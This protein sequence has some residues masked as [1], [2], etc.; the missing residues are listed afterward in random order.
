[1]SQ[2]QKLTSE[3]LNSGTN[4]IKTEIH[5]LAAS[6]VMSKEFDKLDEDE[7]KYMQLIS[8]YVTSSFFVEESK[9]IQVSFVQVIQRIASATQV[10]LRDFI[11][12]KLYIIS[13]ATSLISNTTMLPASLTYVYIIAC[14]GLVS[15]I[16]SA[17]RKFDDDGKHDYEQLLLGIDA[18][19]DELVH[20]INLVFWWEGQI[21]SPESK[22]GIIPI[23]DA[24]ITK[25]INTDINSIASPSEEEIQ[26]LQENIYDRKNN[27]PSTLLISV[28]RRFFTQIG[29][30]LEEINEF[31]RSSLIW[32]N[33][34]IMRTVIVPDSTVHTTSDANIIKVTENTETTQPSEFKAIVVPAIWLG[35]GL[36]RMNPNFTNAMIASLSNWVG[37][38][39]E[40]A[41]VPGF[42][43]IATLS[44]A[45][46]TLMP[47]LPK[48]LPASTAIATTISTIIPTG[49]FSPLVTGILV[50]GGVGV[51]LSA[52]LIYVSASHALIQQVGIF[53]KEAVLGTTATAVARSE[54]TQAFFSSQRDAIAEMCT[55]GLGL[56]GYLYRAIDISGARDELTVCIESGVTNS[57]LYRFFGGGIGNTIFG[58]L[59]QI[60]NN[61]ASTLER[62]PYVGPIVSNT[63]RGVFTLTTSLMDITSAFYNSTFTTVHMAVHATLTHIFQF[64]QIIVSRSIQTILPTEI[65]NYVNLFIAPFIGNYGA[66]ITE[67][68]LLYWLSTAVYSTLSKC[69][70]KPKASKP[71]T[72]SL[73][74]KQ[75]IRK[76]KIEAEK[77]R[78]LENIARNNATIKELVHSIRQ[79]IVRDKPLYDNIDTSVLNWIEQDM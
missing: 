77:K 26:Y 59:L 4:I 73:D 29:Y 8:K 39:I 76:Q 7:Q 31:F 57:T 70:R 64:I 37:V 50:V 44:I 40:K 51:M 74:Q 36:M 33:N 30:N 27:N 16:Q 61:T 48:V 78:L 28:A 12:R 45:K 75:D 62:V 56:T 69:F 15:C 42:T 18:C 9:G 43:G 21:T 54:L 35:Y 14:Q 60:G 13:A 20:C 19:C 11:R 22:T 10:E 49:F 66:I 6:G 46:A 41:A 79:L 71:I 17:L 47:L 25:S 53:M 1:M 24:E 23:L 2:E 5:K 72:A 58:H 55:R 32:F 52:G 34:V 38:F 67:I 68:Y 65:G 3:L 63:A